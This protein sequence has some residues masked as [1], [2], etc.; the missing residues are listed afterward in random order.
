[1]EDLME[2]TIIHRGEGTASTVAE[3]PGSEMPLIKQVRQSLNYTRV[4]T[5]N[6]ESRFIRP[7]DLDVLLPGFIK[8]H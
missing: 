1:M 6:K 5:A 7:A 2:Q 3:L 8:R 4:V